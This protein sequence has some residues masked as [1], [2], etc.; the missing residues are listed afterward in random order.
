MNPYVAGVPGRIRRLCPHVRLVYLVGD[1]VARVLKSYREGRATGGEHR[2]WDQVLAELDRPSS[3]RYL[4][5][6]R[7]GHQL[8]LYLQ[9]FPRESMHLIDQDE[10]RANRAAVLYELFAFLGVD[11]DF[12]SEH[13][14]HELNTSVDQRHWGGAGEV[15]RK[16]RAVEIFRRSP[17]VARRPVVALARRLMSKPVQSIALEDEGHALIASRLAPD[18]T[19]FRELTGRPFGHW[20]L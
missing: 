1:P 20:P 19:R 3:S 16:S 6:S 5:P 8:S 12:T 13:F 4:A 15:L 17:P 18:I 9:H 14:R 10:L 11:P 2:S 7:Y